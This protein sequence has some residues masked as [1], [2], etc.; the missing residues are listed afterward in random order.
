MK[1]TKRSSPLQ[2]ARLCALAITFLA[3]SGCAVR[4][5]VKPL[6]SSEAAKVS[7]IELRVMSAGEALPDRRGAS[8]TTSAAAAHFVPGVNPVVP[9]TAGGALGV[10][11]GFA[12]VDLII[13][14]DKDAKHAVRSAIVSEQVA[15]LRD[16]IRDLDYPSRVEADFR[17]TLAR[18]SG[19]GSVPFALKSEAGRHDAPADAAMSVKVSHGFYNWAVA[20]RPGVPP[21]PAGLLLDIRA[22]VT[23]VKKDG[24]VLMRETLIFETPHSVDP[25]DTARLAWWNQNQRFRRLMDLAGQAFSAGLIEQLLTNLRFTDEADYLDRAAQDSQIPLRERENKLETAL[26]QFRRCE[27]FDRVTMK[28]PRFR[29]VRGQADGDVYIGLVCDGDLSSL[30]GKT[31]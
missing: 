22:E 6:Y 4:P 24:S 9:A 20:R 21:L 17:R 25:E 5:P 1:V 29:A 23:L 30:Q 11:L 10:A 16:Q 27:D 7:S 18:A 15:G 3:I 8:S 28:A 12:L 2:G 31:P 26:E 19:A 14:A 13:Q